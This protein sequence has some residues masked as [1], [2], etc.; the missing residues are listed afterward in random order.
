MKHISQA[1]LIAVLAAA[2]IAAEANSSAG[3]FTDLTITLVDLDPDDGITP[4]FS[5]A[6]APA[7]HNGSFVQSQNRNTGDFDI[8][9]NSDWGSFFKDTAAS[10]GRTGVTASASTSATGM[11]SQGQTSVWR[12]DYYA[13]TYRSTQDRL[14]RLETVLLSPKTALTFS[15]LASTSA[16]AEQDCTTPGCSYAYAIV[17][18]FG[19][20]FV[21][22][23]PLEVTY[24]EL[25]VRSDACAV[26]TFYC[27]APTSSDA[28]SALLGV[29]ISNTFAEQASVG[30]VA[31]AFIH[32]ERSVTAV[33]EP[34]SWALMLF[35][36][37]ALGAMRARSKALETA[38][39][40]PQLN[41][42][43][44]PR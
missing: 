23:S 30:F 40:G 16:T 39:G 28:D 13:G 32:G 35:G 22:G 8:H 1:M 4:W 27:A 18:V 19:S 3:S 9:N 42:G 44:A 21:G 15:G 5:F 43:R 7:N 41:A 6:P 33:P 24:T 36:V 38:A 17:E 12:S 37:A 20:G 31:A 14:G 26:A 29:T 2:G 10:L 34:A 11:L 25:M